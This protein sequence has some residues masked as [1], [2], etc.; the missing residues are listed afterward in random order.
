MP[1]DGPGS[2]EPRK[3]SRGPHLLFMI[4]RDRDPPAICWAGLPRSGSSQGP[5]WPGGDQTNILPLDLILCILNLSSSLGTDI[6]TNEHTEH[7]SS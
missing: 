1:R 5:G 7:G 6:I 3:S 4:L 2:D